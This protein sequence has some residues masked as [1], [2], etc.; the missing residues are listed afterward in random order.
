MFRVG[1]GQDSHEFVK[2]GDKKPLKLGGVLISNERGLKGNSDGDV[3]L[4]A[5][6]NALSQ[7]IGERSIGI[8]ADPK[9]E[10]GITDSKEYL[11]TILSMVKEKGYIINNVGIMI[12]AKKPKIEEHVCKMK[13]SLSKL[14]KLEESQIGITAT[15]GEN[16]TAFGR[17]EGIQT[18][19]IVS[20][21]KI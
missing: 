3:V 1:F 5:L 19:V 4:H 12:E 17:G 6:F 15:S 16:L 7:A 21:V 9:F 8:Y 14:L 2:D 10:R 13:K 18:F 20:L 11:K